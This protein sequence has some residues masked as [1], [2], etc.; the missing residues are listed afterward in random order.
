M[1]AQID[2]GVVTGLQFFTD[3]VTD[4]SPVRALSGLMTL[5]VFG[6]ASTMESSLTI[7]PLQGMQL[8]TLNLGG[9]QKLIRPF[10]PKGH[11]AY[12]IWTFMFATRSRTLNR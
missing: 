10:A 5:G 11:A 3:N 7:A 8:K 9:N 1:H 4:I 12:L 6:K 2:N